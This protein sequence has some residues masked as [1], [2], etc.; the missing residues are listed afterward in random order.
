MIQCICSKI[1]ICYRH[2]HA[3]KL[4]LTQIKRDR[5]GK[6]DKF[7]LRYIQ[8]SVYCTA[9][10]IF[11]LLTNDKRVFFAQ[12]GRYFNLVVNFI[13]IKWFAEIQADLK[14]VSLGAVTEN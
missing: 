12:M 9:G 2:E 7:M 11:I 4:L 1:T 5:E 8:R 6:K 14:Q 10:T 3:A 13:N